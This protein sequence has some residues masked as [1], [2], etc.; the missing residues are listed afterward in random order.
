MEKPIIEVK[1][2]GKKYD[3]AH[4]R[5]GYVALRDV[6]ATI[7]RRPFAF[8]VRRA[9]QAV[10]IEK[11]EEFWALRGVNFSVQRGEIVG[12]IGSNGAGK[13]TLLKILSQITPPTEGE[14]ILRGRVGSL[15]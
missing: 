7:M 3:I 10:G 11:R 8:L 6:I 5:G 15:L 14:V 2:L 13:S 12:V 9:K 1:N 4:M